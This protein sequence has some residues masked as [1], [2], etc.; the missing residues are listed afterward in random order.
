MSLEDWVDW[1]MLLANVVT[2]FGLPFAIVVFIIEKRKEALNDDEEVYQRLSDDYDDFQKLV[3]DNIDLHLL[4]ETSTE[5]LSPEQQS[6]MHIIFDLLVSIFERAFILVYEESLPKQR[7][8]MWGSWA[9]YMREWIHRDDFFKLLPVLLRG[10]DPDFVA[11][12]LRLVR[13]ERGVVL[14][15]Q[16]RTRRI[17]KPASDRA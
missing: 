7:Q 5:G 2:I 16:E 8:R 14:V 15:V 6:R 17:A 12:M 13:E 4:E 11:Y 1:S 10:E 3:L 9:D